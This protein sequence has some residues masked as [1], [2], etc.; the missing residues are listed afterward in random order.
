MEDEDA[1]LDVRISLSDWATTAD[2]KSAVSGR[3]FERLN[4]RAF[5][6]AGS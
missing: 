5:R 3:V 6:D 2:E 4:M 1:W